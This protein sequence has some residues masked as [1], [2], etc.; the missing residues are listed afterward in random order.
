MNRFL[1]VLVAAVIPVASIVVVGSSASASGSSEFTVGFGGTGFD[2]S[3]VVQALPDASVIAVAKHGF[4][5]GGSTSFRRIG[6]DG[7]TRWVTSVPD[8]A[9]NGFYGSEYMSAALL[10]ADTVLVTGYADPAGASNTR[11]DAV[12]IAVSSDGRVDTVDR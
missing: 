12:V 4:G 9:D 5:P 2:G 10:N 8:G 11:F 7:V 3:V 1:R 6:A